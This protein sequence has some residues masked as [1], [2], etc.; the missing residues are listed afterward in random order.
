MR[1]KNLYC[2]NDLNFKYYLKYLKFKKV[3]LLENNFLK[4]RKVPEKNR[5][6]ESDKVFVL[7]KL[8]RKFFCLKYMCSLLIIW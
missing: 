5:G 2:K 4:R 1:I 7:F 8:K 3:V 6:E